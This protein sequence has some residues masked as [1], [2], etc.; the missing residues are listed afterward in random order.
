MKITIETNIVKTRDGVASRTGKPYSMRTQAAFLRGDRVAGEIEL[1]LAND[2]QAYQLGDY[3]IDLE[4]SVTIGNFGSLR[5]N[6][7]LKPQVKQQPAAYPKA[8]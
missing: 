4:R 5:F 3:E 2:Q 7:V 8:S 1:L 6:P